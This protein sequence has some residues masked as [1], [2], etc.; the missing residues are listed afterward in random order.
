VPHDVRDRL[1]G[2]VR[3]DEWAEEI[4]YAV[5]VLPAEQ[6]SPEEIAAWARDHWTIENS[7]HWIRDVTFGE[8]AR[9]IRTRNTPA[10]MAVL[11][12][13]VRGSLRAAG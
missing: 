4:V 1:A 9:S 5:T 8:D 13:I 3:V 6:A 12:D 10:V 2:G 11:G 7:V